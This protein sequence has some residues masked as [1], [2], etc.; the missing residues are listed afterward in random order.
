MEEAEGAGGD[1]E[2]GGG[3]AGVQEGG[4]LGEEEGRVHGGGLFLGGGF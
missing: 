4:G 2:G 1:G 3:L